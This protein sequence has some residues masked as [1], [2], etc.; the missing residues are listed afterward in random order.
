MVE[1]SRNVLC[2][3]CLSISYSKVFLICRQMLLNVGLVGLDLLSSVFYSECS[4]VH[5]MDCEKQRT[6]SPLL[7]EVSGLPSNFI[8]KRDVSK[9]ILMWMFVISVQKKL[10]ADN[11]SL[12]RIFFLISVLGS[13][14]I[15]D[16]ILQKQKI[17][18][19]VKTPVLITA[20]GIS[21]FWTLTWDSAAC[22]KMFITKG[23]ASF[24]CSAVSN[25][26]FPYF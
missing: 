18:P 8:T 15:C 9:L 17:K 20:L 7:H 1:T 22:L 21:M 3:L 25:T 10:K 19:C 4:S 16:V 23:E 14:G 5:R 26:L 12:I 24:K 11:F 2:L 13:Q 6:S